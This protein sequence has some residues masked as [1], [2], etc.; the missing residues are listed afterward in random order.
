[1]T[2]HDAKKSLCVDFKPRRKTSKGSLKFLWGRSI[3]SPSKYDLIGQPEMQDSDVKPRVGKPI[4]IAVIASLNFL[5]YLIVFFV[6]L[7]IGFLFSFGIWLDDIAILY[8]AVGLTCSWKLFKHRAWSWYLAIIMWIGEGIFILWAPTT[9]L[10]ELFPVNVLV[11]VSVGAFRFASVS[12]F[13]I[14]RVRKIFAV[15][16]RRQ[17]E[18]G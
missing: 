5:A 13:A 1:M 11:Y 17:L 14:K 7:I 2:Q 18:N 4:G 16:L 10:Y 12:Y 8:L 15:D 3:F 6:F 9:T